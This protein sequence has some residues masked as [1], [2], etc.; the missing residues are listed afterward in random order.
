MCCL[1]AFLGALCSREFG[2][3][4]LLSIRVRASVLLFSFQ[5]VLILRMVQLRLMMHRQLDSSGGEKFVGVSTPVLVL[6]VVQLVI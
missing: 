2:R 3:E 1:F 6:G 4:Q 5:L